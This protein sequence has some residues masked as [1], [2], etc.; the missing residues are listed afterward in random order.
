M[1][2][3]GAR[4]LYVGPVVELG[5]HA[6]AVGELSIALDGDIELSTIDGPLAGGPARSV[7]VPAGAR[8]LMRVNASRIACLYVDV[9]APDADRLLARMTSTDNGFARDHV[10]EARMIVSLKAF[11]ADEIPRPDCKVLLAQVFDLSF[12]PGIDPRIQAALKAIHAEPD[13]RHRSAVLARSLGMSESGFRHGF[14][15]ATGVTLKRYRVWARLTAA[16]TAAIRGES[17]TSAAHAA[18]FASSA[19]LSAAYRN[20]FGMTPSGFL[21]V[22]GRGAGRSVRGEPGEKHPPAPDARP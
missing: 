9:S 21:A 6:N 14:R 22:Y 10:D 18:G 7:F 5:T 8:H 13:R 4:Q 12:E 2:S 16:M 17:L 3:W 11:L 20:M 15:T 1:L 19:H